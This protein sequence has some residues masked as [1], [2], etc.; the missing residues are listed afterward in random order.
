DYGVGALYFSQQCVGRLVAPAGIDL[1]ADMPLPEKLLEVQR[2][3]AEGD[4]RAAKIYDTIGVYFGYG[5]AHYA[6]FYEF[7]YLLA[8]GRVTSGRGG[9][10][11]LERARE[12]LDTEF[13]ELSKKVKF[14]VPGE[15]EKRHGQAM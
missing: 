8:L 9:E 15:T 14:H 5:I 7:R 3:M 10:I 2:L 13:P 12:V 1:P 11:I 4:E 6:D